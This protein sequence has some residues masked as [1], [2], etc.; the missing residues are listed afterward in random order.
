[1]GAATWQRA[2]HPGISPSRKTPPG[3]GKVTAMAWAMAATAMMA[4]GFLLVFGTFGL[5][6]APL[7]PRR[8]ST[9][10]R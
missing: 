9:R 3:C 5:V 4:P 8:R 1:M 7:P 10:P 2:P 6:I